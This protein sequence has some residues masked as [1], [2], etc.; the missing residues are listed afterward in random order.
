MAQTRPATPAAGTI[1]LVLLGGA[2]A[3][4]AGAFMLYFRHYQSDLL[5]AVRH[6]TGYYALA[7]VLVGFLTAIGL[8]LTRP[9]GP[10]APIIA[11]ISAIVALYVGNRLGV[12]LYAVTHGGV[13]GGDFLIE[14][15][16][17]RFDV[18]DLLAPLVAGIIG[19]LRVAM[20]AGSLPPR[21]S[22]GRPYPPT[23]GQPMP[24]QPMPG[25]PMH[26]QPPVPGQ[27][28]Q[29]PAQPGQQ[30]Y[31]PPAVPGGPY[32]GGSPPSG[33]A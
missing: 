23:P 1:A 24:G 20:V 16:K 33:G 18:E 22:S 29:P 11:V 17:Y 4:A 14:V 15:M 6:S 32:Q 10:V 31:A 25:Q 3:T 12:I 19:G 9:R 5:E 27:P 30:P 2:V 8:M 28:F 13:P 7:C 26:G 21:G